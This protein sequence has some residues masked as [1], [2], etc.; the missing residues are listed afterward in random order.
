M[1]S[2]RF[3]VVATKPASSPE[4]KPFQPPEHAVC[5]DVRGRAVQGAPRRG[6]HREPFDNA[7]CVD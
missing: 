5:A 6:K 4:I 3:V 7:S 1:A 2:S